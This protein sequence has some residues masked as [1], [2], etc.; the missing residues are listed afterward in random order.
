MTSRGLLPWCERIVPYEGEPLQS[1]DGRIGFVAPGKQSLGVR[2]LA[3]GILQVRAAIPPGAV[4]VEVS[5]VARASRAGIG[6]LGGNAKPFAPVVLAKLDQPITWEPGREL[7]HDADRRV[8]IS[9]T[10][11]KVRAT[12][13]IPEGSAADSIYVQIANDGDADGAY[14]SVALSFT[15]EEAE[16]EEE[17]VEAPP[18]AAP[19]SSSGGCTAS[20]TASVPGVVPGI[21]LALAGL[22]ARRRRR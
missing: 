15:V 11:G 17:E 19:A 10:S 20:S 21:A 12:F 7:S 13:A 16:P 2:K 22:L 6:P 1:R 14:D 3:P 8:K 5:F 9:A 18:P 4:S